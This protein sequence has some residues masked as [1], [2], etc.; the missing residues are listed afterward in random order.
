MRKNRKLKKW[1][2]LGIITTMLLVQGSAAL[3]A[4]GWVKRSGNW[5]YYNEKGVKTTGWQLVKGTWYYMNSKGVMQTGWL[6]SKNKWYYLTESGAMKTGWLLSKNKWYYL[7]PNGDMKTGWLWNG[8]HWYYLNPN[9]DMKTGWLWNGGHWYYLN[10]D[11]D[12]ATGFLTLSGKTYYLNPNGDMVSGFATI[13]G[14]NYYF[15][16]DGSMLKNTTAVIE[17][18]TYVFDENGAITSAKELFQSAE[19]EKAVEYLKKKKSE[20]SFAEQSLKETESL[21]K[22]ARELAKQY[23]EGKVVGNTEEGILCYKSSSLSCQ[24][25]IDAWLKD[26]GIEYY[27][28]MACTEV[29]FACYENNGIYYWVCITEDG[30][31][32][33]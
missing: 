9:G 4:T 25:A 17:D 10:P 1:F 28:L 21:K 7:N 14:K 6:L 15:N 31:L 19:E 29:G 2:S 32:S 5:Y 16:E 23:A 20:Q 30:K 33:V 3:A 24:E 8:G 13:S 27:H 22:T 18:V 12:M 26:I 11:G